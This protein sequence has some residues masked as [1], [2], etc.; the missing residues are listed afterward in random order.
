L[1]EIRDLIFVFDKCPYIEKSGGIIGNNITKKKKTQ[2][3]EL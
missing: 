3:A 2:A 1:A